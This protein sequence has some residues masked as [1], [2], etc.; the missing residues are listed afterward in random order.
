MFWLYNCIY[1]GSQMKATLIKYIPR[2]NWQHCIN[3]SALLSREL[4][5]LQ[6]YSSQVLTVVYYNNFFV[7]ERSKKC[8]KNKDK[9]RRVERFLVAGD[10]GTHEIACCMS[11]VYSKHCMSLTCPTNSWPTVSFR[12]GSARVGE[13]VDPS[14]T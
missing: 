6:I 13:F 2:Q 11:V 14:T 10:S 12:R 4:L 1:K 8:I 3:I 5:E 9:Q 7:G